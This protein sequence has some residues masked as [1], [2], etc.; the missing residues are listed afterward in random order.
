MDEMVIDCEDALRRLQG[1]KVLFV[2][3]VEIFLQ[4]APLQ[5]DGL[6]YF[7]NIR[8]C[9]GLA[10]AAHF[11][12][13]SSANVGAKKIC[14]LFGEIERA[15]RQNNFDEAHKIFEKSLLEFNEVKN[16]FPKLRSSLLHER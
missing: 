10:E 13:G 15:A 14:Q 16:Y 2:E 11:L 7:I 1:D 4:D 8:D 6:R 5:I 9:K 12:K 3:L